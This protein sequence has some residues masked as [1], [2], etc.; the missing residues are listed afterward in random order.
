M[1]CSIVDTLYHH[2]E[3]WRSSS[4]VLPCHAPEQVPR[5]MLGDARRAV[6][7]GTHIGG[8]C[9]GM[10]QDEV[11][12]TA[13]GATPFRVTAGHLYCMWECNT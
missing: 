11:L 4:E 12:H 6:H 13:A 5:A 8:I 1:W 9:R 2:L 10:S 3:I 7:F